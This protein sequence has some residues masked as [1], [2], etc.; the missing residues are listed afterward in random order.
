MFLHN[1]EELQNLRKEAEERL[2]AAKLRVLV[3]A[4][5]GCIASGSK[6]IYDK[7]KELS[8]G[9]GQVSVEFEGEV[10]HPEIRKSGCHGF[11]EMGPLMRIEPL[12]ILYIKVKVEDCEEIYEKTICQGQPIERLLYHKDGQ[13]YQSEEAIPFYAGQM[14]LVLKNCGHIDAENIE[15]YIAVGG[16]SA[17][18]KVLFDIDKDTAL[19]MMEESGLRGRGGGGFPAG[20][21]WKHHDYCV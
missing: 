15:E 5:T 2:H 3:C 4:G 8:E 11:C 19:D 10:P 13:V 12:G 18:E 20:R 7:M 16:Y 17:L 1:R 6:E 14:R 21:K 9:N